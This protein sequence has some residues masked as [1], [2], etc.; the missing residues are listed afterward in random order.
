MKKW[1]KVLAAAAAAGL[2]CFGAGMLAA[3]RSPAQPQITGDLIVTRLADIQELAVTD[4][5]YTNV[6]KFENRVDFY[7]WKVPLTTKRFIIS[8]DGAI[9]AG[10]EMDGVSAVMDG[11]KIRITIPKAKILSHEVDTDSIQVFDE[12]KNI[13]NPITITDYV[14]FSKDQKAA[15]EKE[16]LSKGLLAQAQNRAE[17]VIRQW[18]D[19]LREGTHYTVEINGK[20]GLACKERADGPS[21]LLEPWGSNVVKDLLC[22]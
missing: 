18:V 12:T 10:I 7:G 21:L 4:Y 15:V 8:Y 1:V 17:E 20:V 13:F 3:G 9:K 2:L 16:A 22:R 14:N 19:V 5:T 11:T 6:G